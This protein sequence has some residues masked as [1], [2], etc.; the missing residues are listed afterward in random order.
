MA[1]GGISWNDLEHL[2]V[3]DDGRLYWKGEAVILEKRLRLE[4]YQ[5]VLATLATAGTVLSG[6]HPFGSSFGWW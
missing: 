1:R 6:V 3:G 4:R 2:E 5:I